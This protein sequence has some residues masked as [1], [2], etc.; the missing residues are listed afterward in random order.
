VA[1]ALASGHSQGPRELRLWERSLNAPE[2][3]SCVRLSRFQARFRLG[4]VPQKFSPE[5]KL[6]S[7]RVREFRFLI[8]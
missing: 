3:S 6:I 1:L 4:E 2:L 5:A 8:A 7:V